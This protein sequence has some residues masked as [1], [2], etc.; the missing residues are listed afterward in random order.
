MIGRI[1]QLC[2]GWLHQQAPRLSRFQRR[3]PQMLLDW[4]DSLKTCAP[5]I[6]WIAGETLLRTGSALPRRRSP[7]RTII[8]LAALLPCVA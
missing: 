4:L 7:M 6:R 2:G 5:T 1:A 8:A 3:A